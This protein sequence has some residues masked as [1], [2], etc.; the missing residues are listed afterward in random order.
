MPRTI[1]IAALLAGALPLLAIATAGAQSTTSYFVTFE[2]TWS[3]ETHPLDFPDAPHFSPMIGVTHDASVS[4]WNEGELASEGIERMAET[5]NVTP[6][7]EEMQAAI[8]AGSGGELMLGELMDSPDVLTLAF[9]ATE[10]HSLVTLV[11]MLAPSPDW[12]VGVS[13]LSLR[14][15]E[16]WIPE[17]AVDL[18][19]YDSGTD[20]GTTFTAPN[21]DTDPAELIFE[22]T[23]YAFANGVPVG[24]FI[25]TQAAVGVDDATTPV[26]PVVRAAPNP[27]RTFVAF[28]GAP[29]EEASIFDATGRRVR[30]LAPATSS[31]DA[32]DDDGR[33]VA[34]GVYFLRGS[35]PEGSITQRLVVRR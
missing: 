14:D 23:D 30:G 15:E 26:A 6:L 10:A 20:S 22:K 31:W 3:E 35:T 4:F 27:L 7:D 8:D 25:F 21:D 13:G 29:L 18:Y 32:R 28:S 33:R 11:S 9:Q 12:F 1:R 24:R 16:G 34:P 5:G 2:A 17:V 19:V